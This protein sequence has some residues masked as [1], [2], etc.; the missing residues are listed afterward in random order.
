MKQVL[1]LC[2]TQIRLT[3]SISCS[4]DQSSKVAAS[5]LPFSTRHVPT[6]RS[7]R[8]GIKAPSEAGLAVLS[9]VPRRFPHSLTAMELE[10]RMGRQSTVV[11]WGFGVKGGLC[12]GQGVAKDQIR[13]RESIS[14]MQGNLV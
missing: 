12:E 6:V 3:V 2:D 8:R 5:P 4:P 7:L 1:W 11:C 9:R 14:G 10:T 13:M